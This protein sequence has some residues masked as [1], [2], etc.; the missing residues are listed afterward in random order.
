MHGTAEAE[1]HLAAGQLAGDVASVGQRPGEPVQLGHDEGAVGAT[2]S[3]C[4]AQA[5]A[6][7]VGAGQAV[8]D[9]HPLGVDTECS[10]RVA[11][12]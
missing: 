4:L 11:V 12:R 7:P 10:K 2:G 8:I 5:G 3:E 1:L 6:V 9:I